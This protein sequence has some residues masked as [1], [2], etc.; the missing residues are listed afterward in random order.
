MDDLKYEFYNTGKILWSTSSVNCRII[1]LKNI[2]T[3]TKRAPS[4]K[5]DDRSITPMCIQVTPPHNM[6][7]HTIIESPPPCI[8]ENVSG[9]IS[10]ACQY[11]WKSSPL[12]G[13][14][15]LKKNPH[16]RIKLSSTSQHRMSDD[17]RQIPISMF[18]DG[19][20]DGVAEEFLAFWSYSLSDV[21]LLSLN[22]IERLY[23]YLS[24]NPNVSEIFLGRQCFFVPYSSGSFK[25]FAI[26][27]LLRPISLAT[28][29][30]DKFSLWSS[31]ILPRSVKSYFTFAH[32]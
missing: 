3:Y 25:N 24:P 14:S 26:T 23:A 1:L 4:V 16:P 12:A 15:R 18:C 22:C 7:L 32:S 27:V 20:E 11:R 30:W 21:V 13:L 9:W 29:R 10:S 5:I 19:K 2:V 8:F 31:K 28:T 6:R 17:F